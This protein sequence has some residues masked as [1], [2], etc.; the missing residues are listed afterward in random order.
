MPRDFPVRVFVLVKIDCSDHRRASPQNRFD[1]R[2]QSLAICEDAG[3]PDCGH[4]VPQSE[5]LTC[6]LTG[7]VINFNVPQFSFDPIERVAI[8]QALENRKPISLNL[9][10]HPSTVN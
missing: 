8:D 6:S 5:R 9:V 7:P 4:Q 3:E 10:S 2:S 1:I